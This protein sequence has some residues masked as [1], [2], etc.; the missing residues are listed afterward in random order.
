MDVLKGL[1]GQ[2]LGLDCRR[3]CM[4][5]LLF[6]ASDY[7]PNPGGIAAYI[8]T[9][10]RG[11]IKLGIDVK[12]L[13]L[14]HPD[15]KRR[16]AFLENYEDWVEAFPLV[17]DDRPKSFLA[18][19]LVSCLEMVRCVWPF[20]RYFL[21]RMSFFSQSSEAISRLNNTLAQEK[22]AV[23]VFGHM[24]INF[25]S[26]VF[27]LL[28][29]RIPYAIIAH[30]S[31]IYKTANRVNDL[32]RRG[33]LLKKA[34]WIAAN[35]RHTQSLLEAWGLPSGRIAIIHPPLPEEAVGRGSRPIEVG[36]EKSFTIVT[37]CRLVRAKAVDLVLRAL[38]LLAQKN[39]SFRYVV[40]GDGAERRNLE[41]LAHELGVHQQTRFTGYIN[42]GD[43]WSLL[44]SADVFVMPSRVEPSK[45]HEG[46]GLAFVEAG[47]CGI[48]VIGT[49]VG[50]IPDAIIDGE[51]GIL[52]E[53][54]SPSKLADALVA[55]HHDLEK[56][57]KMGEAGRKRA[58]TE[59]S[60]ATVAARFNEELSKRL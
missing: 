49:R 52:I 3:R 31:E 53:P 16:M 36:R 21:N 46:F 20:G 1:V 59:F 6:I 11:L 60:S 7:K 22:P 28:E 18:N 56:R 17:F 29:Q 57:R 8:D 48:P 5:K 45:S 23:V 12:V 4:G 15:D 25:Y 58:Q 27:P 55:L 51:T 13:V 34:R 19:R 26:L 10:A 30:D 33:M 42:E 14:V 44:E 37:V 39:I 54:E 9:L 43:K 24:Y 35:S 47:A 41:Q 40:A 38:Q 50:G 32:V 2:G